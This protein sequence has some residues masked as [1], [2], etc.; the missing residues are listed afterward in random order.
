MDSLN[1]L[2][3][4][5]DW[6]NELDYQAHDLAVSYIKSNSDL[7]DTNLEEFIRNC[8]ASCTLKV[9]DMLLK[10]GIELPAI[11]FPEASLKNW[12]K[13]MFSTH[14]K[15]YMSKTCNWIDIEIPEV[16]ETL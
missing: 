13:F 12:E 1:T 16:E 8:P 5:Q 4:I 7:L 3:M 6:I 2:Q 11:G 14:P 10:A 15:D 9:E